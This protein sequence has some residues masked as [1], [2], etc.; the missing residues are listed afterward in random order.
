M[1]F[2]R[3]TAH[4]FVKMIGPSFL[5]SIVLFT[6]MTNPKPVEIISM[7][8]TIHP[9]YLSSRIWLYI[10]IYLQ[11]KT[12]GRRCLKIPIFQWQKVQSFFLVNNHHTSVNSYPF[13]T[14][15]VGYFQH[16]SLLREDFYYL[17]LWKT[18]GV[19]IVKQLWKMSDYGLQCSHIS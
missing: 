9:V 15:F 2:T 13:C 4:E 11:F 18:E 3:E 5:A 16:D 12:Y 1:R 7:L 14:Y 17:I 8:L 6:I 19:A 10:N